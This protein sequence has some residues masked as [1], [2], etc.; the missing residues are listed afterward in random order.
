MDKL[1]GSCKEG[2]DSTQGRKAARIG[3]EHKK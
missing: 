2:L 1:V 3:A